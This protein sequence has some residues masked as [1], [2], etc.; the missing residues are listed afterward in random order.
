MKEAVEIVEDLLAQPQVKILLPTEK[1]WKIFSDLVIEGQTGGV[2]MMDAHLAALAIEH[3]ATLA[4]TDR[5]F[6]RFSKLKM[7][8][9]LLD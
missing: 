7:T 6:V 2:M 9:P 8:N 5:D 1:H 4:T 3:G